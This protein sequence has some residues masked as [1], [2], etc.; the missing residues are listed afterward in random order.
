MGYTGRKIY[1]CKKIFLNDIVL[2]MVVHRKKRET[3][4]NKKLILTKNHFNKQLVIELVFYDF[5]HVKKA[6]GY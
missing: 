1:S 4:H 5:I 3:V 2:S 6:G